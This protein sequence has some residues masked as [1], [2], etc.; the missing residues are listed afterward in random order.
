VSEEVFGE[1]LTFLAKF[2]KT[3]RTQEEFEQ[4]LNVFAK[5]FKRVQ[6]HNAIPD[7]GFELAI[8]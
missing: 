8:N 7:S 5:N 6:D 3:Q 2:G 1:Y 4:R